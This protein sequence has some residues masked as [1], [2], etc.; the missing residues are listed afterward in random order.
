MQERLVRTPAPDL[1]FRQGDVVKRIEIELAQVLV[2]L[3]ILAVAQVPVPKMIE[4]PL[5]MR[6]F[7]TDG[8]VE[9]ICPG[10]IIL[11]LEGSHAALARHFVDAPVG[12]PPTADLS[13]P[14]HAGIVQ[15][16]LL[17]KLTARRP[18]KSPICNAGPT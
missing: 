8:V 9:R 1:V 2:A 4:R 14:N 18:G 15:A 10:R 6:H 16:E 7:C 5:D 11:P 17:H 12:G 3:A 13:P